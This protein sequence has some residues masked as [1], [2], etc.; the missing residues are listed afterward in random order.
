MMHTEIVTALQEHQKLI[1]V[2]VD[3]DGY[4][5]IKGLQMSVGSPPFGN[6]LRYRSKDSGR[7]E[8]DYIQID[9]AANGES[10]GAIGFTANSASE[11]RDALEA[12]RAADRTAVIHVTVDRDAKVPGFE[13]WWDV[14]VAESSEQ[15]GVEEAQEEYE[16]ARKA[17][18]FYY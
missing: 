7:L 15:E 12:A 2:V 14:P 9:F 6:E 1:I 3:N 10:L 5:V 11:L 17:Q 18:R 8:G 16:R 4:Q 13:S